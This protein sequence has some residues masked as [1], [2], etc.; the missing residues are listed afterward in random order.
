MV[1]AV[2]EGDSYW[3]LTDRRGE[4][5]SASL[6]GQTYVHPR[7]VILNFKLP[8]RRRPLAVVIPPDALPADVHRRLRVRLRLEGRNSVDKALS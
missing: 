5:V 3:S 2:W 8:G 6:S 1:M 7:L 4:C